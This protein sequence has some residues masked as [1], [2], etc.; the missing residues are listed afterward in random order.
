MT[1]QAVLERARSE[2]G[3][4]HV[5]GTAATVEHCEDIAELLKMSRRHPL[6]RPA[7]VKI[8]Q[9]AMPERPDHRD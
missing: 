9:S 3:Q 8:L 7:F 4:S 5:L 6:G 2:S 1:R